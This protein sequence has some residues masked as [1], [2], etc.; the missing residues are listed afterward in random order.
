MLRIRLWSLI[1]VLSIMQGCESMPTPQMGFSDDGILLD[2]VNEKVK[3]DDAW[4]DAVKELQ[5]KTQQEFDGEV[6][7]GLAQYLERDLHILDDAQLSAYVSKIIDRLLTVWQGVKPEI[8][9]VIESDKYF[10]A[11][12]TL[13]HQLHLSTAVFRVLD[14]EDQLASLLAHEISHV[15]LK[16]NHEKSMVQSTLSALEFAELLSADVGSLAEHVGLGSDVQEGAKYGILGF[17]SLGFIWSELFA[18]RWSRKNELEADKLGMDL[19]MR[20]D[21]N[22]E[23]FTAMLEQVFDAQVGRSAR[24]QRLSE[25]ID[26]II[27]DD[28]VDTDKNQWEALVERAKMGMVVKA[29]NMI[30]NEIASHGKEHE[31][32]EVRIDVL[33]EYIINQYDD[34]LPPEVTI[35]PYQAAVGAAASEYRLAQDLQAVE[36]LD[37]LNNEDFNAAKTLAQ[38]LRVGS[39]HDVVSGIMA[40][41]S[42]EGWRRNT[43][44]AVNYLSRLIKNKIHAPSEAYTK[45]AELYI[46]DKKF[47]QAEALLQQGIQRIGRDYKFLPTLVHLNVQADKIDQ[48]EAYT[49]DCQKY[50]EDRKNSLINRM[51]GTSSIYYENCV[52]YLGYD[53]LNPDGSKKSILP[54]IIKNP[55]GEILKPL[56]N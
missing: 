42:V 28:L 15:L 5:Q 18:P 50:D 17:A 20:A 3:D 31:D 39:Q 27:Q 56:S 34:D 46:A 13:D 21:Y 37:A 6:H 16:H 40:K 44:T 53:P 10:N 51:L 24:L 43:K 23:E 8:T 49:L 33:N 22:Y 55:I 7:P 1:F 47:E 30:I 54:D 9:V 12:V 25:K 4:F 29:K 41:S 48:A 2:T 45:L 11:Y 52:S 35:E 32:R 26:E 14:N 36:V 19:V 38:Q